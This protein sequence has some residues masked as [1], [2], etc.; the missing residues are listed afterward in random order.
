VIPYQD[1]PHFKKSTIKG[2][3]GNLVIG[4]IAGVTIA[5]MQGR[6]HYYEGHSISDVVFPIRVFKLMNIEKLVVTNAAGGIG[7]MLEPGD[8]MI[9][10][11]HINLMGTNP[12]IGPND[13]R[14]GTRFPDMSEIY[15]KD[16]ID[17]AIK[18][19]R[20]LH[21]DV[22]KGVYCAF[23][24]PSYETPSEIK[25]AATYGADAA[26]MSTV[27]EAIIANHMNMRVLGISCITNL[28]SGISP[29]KLT[30]TEVVETAN[31]VKG[32]FLELL[33]MMI[34]KL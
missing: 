14:F 1:I 16:L 33:K 13:E 21:I 31:K 5:A 18:C 2:H 26:G 3:A 24:G 29:H 15:N 17:A 30:H 20:E 25:M 22:K 27:P 11:D 28:A 32:K 8:L 23:T 12:L 10:R 4:K 19:M 6:Y 34:P 9:I 7:K